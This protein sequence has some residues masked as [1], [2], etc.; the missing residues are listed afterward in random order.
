MIGA[1]G[2][3]VTR[4][5]AFTITDVKVT[6]GETVAHERVEEIAKKALEG[7]YYRFVPRRFS[8]TYPSEAIL[9]EVKSLPRVKDASI[10]LSDRHTILISI[11]EYYPFALWCRSLSD[12]SACFFLD[13]DGYAFI[14]AP[15]LNGGSMLRYF[16]HEREPKAGEHPFDQNFMA[17]TSRLALSLARDFDF[18]VTHIERTAPDEVIYHLSGGSFLKASLRQSVET[19]TANLSTIL[20]SEEFDHLRPGNFQYID[21]RFGSKVFVN[22]GV[23]ADGTAS[24]TAAEL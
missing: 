9:R 1:A 15:A 3:Y 18:P 5:E 11:T 6:G 4:F 22:E 24:S 2:W 8:F 10:E 12:E 13:A 19:T 16:D 23:A 14:A 20:G 7:E 21:L 17:N